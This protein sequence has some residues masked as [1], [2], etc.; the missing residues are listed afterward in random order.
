MK[1][2]E[3]VKSVPFLLSDNLLNLSLVSLTLF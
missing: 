1:V 3:S 2:D